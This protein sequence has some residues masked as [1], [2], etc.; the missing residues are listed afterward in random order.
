MMTAMDKKNWSFLFFY[1]LA[2]L[3]ALLFMYHEA[4]GH[5]PLLTVVRALIAIFGLM[6]AGYTI[7]LGAKLE[8]QI[9]KFQLQ[10]T[11]L[12]GNNRKMT[13][14]LDKFEQLRQDLT[15]FSEG[16]GEKF[17]ETFKNVTE[18]FD[19][20]KETLKDQK[21]VLKDQRQETMNKFFFDFAFMDG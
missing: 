20:V 21:Q 14:Q 16:Q 17:E 19:S 8:E 18:M 15:K 10:N 1:L 3:V 2:S 7:Y 4:E 11:V 6:S 9:E 13:Q 5:T 12:E